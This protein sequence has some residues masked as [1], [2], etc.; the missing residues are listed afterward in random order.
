MCL[1]LHF[2]EAGLFCKVGG[3]DFFGQHLPQCPRKSQASA[4][5]SYEQGQVFLGLSHSFNPGLP[6][7]DAFR[8]VHL[9]LFIAQCWQATLLQEGLQLNLTYYACL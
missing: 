1:L 6:A 4:A 3:R 9:Q 7:Q 5:L 2:A 8:V